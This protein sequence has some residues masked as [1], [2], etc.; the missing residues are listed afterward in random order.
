MTPAFGARG[1]N[2]LSGQA[3][4]SLMR[5]LQPGFTFPTSEA[6]L[7]LLFRILVRRQTRKF[8]SHRSGM[9]V[10]VKKL[11]NGKRVGCQRGVRASFLRPRISARQA[12]SISAV[13]T[14]IWSRAQ[15]D[16]ALVW[17]SAFRRF[18]TITPSSRVNAEL[19]TKRKI[20]SRAVSKCALWSLS[21]CFSLVRLRLKRATFE[22]Q[23]DHDQRRTSG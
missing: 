1:M 12:E 3:I 16:T 2:A 7:R 19:R 15:L 21:G 11:F 14:A 10:R 20:T 17:S 18:G 6:G 13:E 8:V 4:T 23:F 9:N 22:H 5:S